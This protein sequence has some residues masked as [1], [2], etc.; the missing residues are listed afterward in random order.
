MPE[1]IITE[2]QKKC[3]HIW[4]RMTN[5]FPSAEDEFP[6]NCGRCEVLEESWL[7]YQQGLEE[8]IGKTL[9]WAKAQGIDIEK[10]IAILKAFG[11]E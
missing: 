10:E 4:H 11:N 2:N 1:S 9:A 8:G 5:L 3:E 7:A 6:A